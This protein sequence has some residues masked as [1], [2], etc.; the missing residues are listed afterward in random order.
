MKTLPMSYHRQI[1][2]KLMAGI[3]LSACGG[4]MLTLM[5]IILMQPPIWFIALII[6]V[7]PGAV[8]ITNLSGII[9]ELYWPKLNWD[10]EQKAVKQNMNVL[11]GIA[12]SLVFA[13]LIILPVIVFSLTLLPAALLII[14]GPLLIAWIL[15]S[16]IRRIGPRLILSVDA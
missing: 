7:L 16:I 9:F 6:G 10:N 11:Y 4:I 5:I 15:A 8:L 2:A 1:W 13:A 14:G 3:V 12:L